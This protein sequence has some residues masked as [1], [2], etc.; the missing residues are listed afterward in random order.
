M[1]FPVGSS[2]KDAC[3]CRGYKRHGFDPWVRKIPWRKAW[4]PTPVFLPGVTH[5][6]RGLAGYR[7]VGYRVRHS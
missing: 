5:G 1:G 6:Q 2:S 3:Q 7:P 4:Q